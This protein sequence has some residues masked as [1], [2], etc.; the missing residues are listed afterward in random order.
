MAWLQ[1]FCNA[2]PEIQLEWE[3]NDGLQINQHIDRRV[4]S[5]SLAEFAFSAG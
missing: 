4:G 5:G 1:L 3:N 2:G